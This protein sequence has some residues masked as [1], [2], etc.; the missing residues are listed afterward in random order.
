MLIC[1]NMCNKVDLHSNKELLKETQRMFYTA[2][3]MKSGEYRDGV[4]HAL[5]MLLRF[6]ADGK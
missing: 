6:I 1:H 4:I 2:Q 3:K 5:K